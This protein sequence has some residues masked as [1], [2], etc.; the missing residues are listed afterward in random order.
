MKHIKY[1]PD[2]INWLKCAKCGEAKRPHRI[3]IEHLNVCA[4][5]N[6]EWAAHKANKSNS[7]DNTSV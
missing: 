7:G 1:F 2:R 3:C 4:M 5:S 6:E